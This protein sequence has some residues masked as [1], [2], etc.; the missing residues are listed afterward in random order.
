[1]AQLLAI[2]SSFKHTNSYVFVARAVLANATFCKSRCCTCRL[3]DDCG[4]RQML[5]TFWS[6]ICGRPVPVLCKTLAVSK[7][8][9]LV[10]TVN[11]LWHALLGRLWTQVSDFVSTNHSTHRAFSGGCVVV[12]SMVHTPCRRVQCHG[13]RGLR[14][15]TGHPE[16]LVSIV[17][18]LRTEPSGVRTSAWTGEF[19]L[20]QD[21]QTGAEVHPVSY[22]MG[23]G[24]FLG[25]KAAGAWS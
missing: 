16:W 21:V 24:F 25:G 15:A 18:R 20:L 6:D 4:Q 8:V 2:R 9:S 22:T 19:S 23:I 10:W 12:E 14:P 17:A 7:H 1:V 3:R 5:S 13:K 11:I